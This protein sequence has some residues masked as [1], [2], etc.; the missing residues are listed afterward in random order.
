MSVTVQLLII[1]LWNHNVQMHTQ[2]QHA[3]RVTKTTTAG[4]YIKLSIYILNFH[5]AE[6][7]WLP[8]VV[9]FMASR[10]LYQVL[11]FWLVHCFLNCPCCTMSIR[12]YVIL[13]LPSTWLLL[14]G[15]ST[16][17]QLKHKY[18]LLNTEQLVSDCFLLLKD[19]TIYVDWSVLNVV[20]IVPCSCSSASL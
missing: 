7:S 4:G 18:Q 9:L 19:W 20:G 2:Q 13:L 15:M 11:L 1:Y 17:Q 16:F 6:C 12:P 8:S 5:S 10:F 3:F 14:G